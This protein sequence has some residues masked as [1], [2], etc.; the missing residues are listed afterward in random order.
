MQ[1][2]IIY[3]LKSSVYSFIAIAGFTFMLNM[4]RRL[5]IYTCAIGS[6]AWSVYA[7]LS[8]TALPFIFP[9]FAGALVV[10]TLSEIM[11]MH[12]KHPSIL[13]AIPSIIPFVPGYSVYYTMY[14]VIEKNFDKAVTTGAEAFF[15]SIAIACGIMISSSLIGGLRQKRIRRLSSRSNLVK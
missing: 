11:A 2:S 8:L 5:I 4:P 15:I 14:Y 3:I 1:E 6:I 10:G 9:A 7:A 12:K 13:F